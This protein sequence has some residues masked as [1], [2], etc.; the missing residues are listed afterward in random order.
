MQA[1]GGELHE[2]YRNWADSR[3]PKLK[4]AGEPAPLESPRFRLVRY[5]QPGAR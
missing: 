1:D 2:R 5:T 4:G 3:S